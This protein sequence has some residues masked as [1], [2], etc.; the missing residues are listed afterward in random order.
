MG[1]VYR[2]TDTKLNRD[3]AIKVLPEPFGNDADRMARFTREAQVLASLNHPNIAAIYGVE[4]RALVM[5]LVEGRTL[6]ERIAVG[7]IP[8]HEALPIVK[9]IVEALEYAHERGIVHR[10]LKPANIKITPDGR[11]KVLDFGLAKAVA[12]DTVASD[13]MSSPTLTIRATQLGVIMG[14][15]AYMSPEQAMGKPVDKRADIWSFG[16]VLWEILTGRRLFKGETVT[17]T[18]A[19]VINGPIDFGQLPSQTP[20]AIRGLIRRCLERDA[21]NRLRDIGEARIALEDRFQA[22]ETTAPAIQQRHAFAWVSAAVLAVALVALAFVHFRE[23]AQER[24]RFQFEVAVPEA[25]LGL[26]TVRLS[27]DGRFLAILTAAASDSTKIWVRDLKGNTTRFVASVATSDV[28]WSRDSKQMAYVSNGKLYAAAPEAGT[29][30]AVMG[31]PERITSGAWMESDVILLG[32]PE[33]LF[34]AS[35]SGDAVVPIDKQAC[36]WVTWLPGRRYLYRRPDGLWAGSLD[37]GKPI[38][39]PLN[40]PFPNYV[41]P[42]GGGELGQLLFLRDD[43]LFAQR[44]HSVKLRLQDKAIPVA[45]NLAGFSVSWNGVLASV[46]R[47]PDDVRLIWIDLAGRPVQTASETFVQALNPAIRLSPD[48]SRAIVPVAGATGT[49]LWIADLNRKT[50]SRLTFNPAY[51]GIWS[52]DGRKVLWVALGGKVYLRPADGSGRDELLFEKQRGGYVMDW[53]SDGKLVTFAGYREQRLDVWLTAV[54]NPSKL[55]PLLP[56]FSVPTYWAQ[57]SPDSQWIAYMAE[58]Q[59]FVESVPSGRGHWQIST[60]DWPI[61]RRDGKE[62]FYRQGTK[63]M[64]VP[65]HLTASSVEAGKPQGLFDVPPGTRFQVSRDG[66]RFLIALPVEGASVS[67]PITIDTDWRAGL[68]K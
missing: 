50:M 28:F 42:A 64:A 53:S 67:A 49:E 39:I 8:V 45:S 29:P 23:P 59:I 1:E 30:T 58:S 60:G 13:P 38:S 5:E 41:P 36:R 7:A 33:G 57:F 37:G 43:T 34:R 65:V 27:P 10:D 47:A 3:V 22:S 51:S 14:T 63:L 18:L 15:A 2:A 46:R 4:E 55:F 9:Q 24:P 31:I 32:G 48:D 66:Q 6:A 54:G 20:A 44:F 19:A 56:Q 17:D 61:W 40:G 52:P 62:L 26:P 21:R 25:G 11:V 16:V 12:S 35:P 68:T